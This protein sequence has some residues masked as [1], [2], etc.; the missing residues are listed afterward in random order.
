MKDFNIDDYPEVKAALNKV[1]TNGGIA[2][3]KR[4]PRGVTVVEI[5]RKVKNREAIAE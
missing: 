5:T 2:E 4:E 3:V 1:V